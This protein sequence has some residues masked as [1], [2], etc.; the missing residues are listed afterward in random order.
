M[1]TYPIAFENG[2]CKAFEINNVYIGSK[3]VALLLASVEGVTQINCSAHA[4]VRVEFG[5]SGH[6]CVVVEPFGD[7]SRY[8]LGPTDFEKSD[9]DMS[10]IKAVFD[11]YNPPIWMRVIGG[12]VSLDFSRLLARK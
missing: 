7:N 8:W 12:L 1:K 2:H 11:K 9:L 3:K 10:S 5:Y 6:H 4:D